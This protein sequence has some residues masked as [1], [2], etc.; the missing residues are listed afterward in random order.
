MKAYFFHVIINTLIRLQKKFVDKLQKLKSE[1]ENNQ[2]R[3]VSTN[4]EPR[5]VSWL[6]G[7]SNGFD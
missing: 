5:T 4:L 3:G 2:Q 7:G 6:M 1:L